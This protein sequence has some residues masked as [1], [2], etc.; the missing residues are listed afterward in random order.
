MRVKT[1]RKRNELVRAAAQVFLA[2]GFDR[3]LMSEVSERAG[4]SKGTLYRYFASKEDL[5]FAVIMELTASGT[6]P[7]FDTVTGPEV[8]FE[9]QLQR[10][11]I[12]FVK[13]AYSPQFQAMRR[14][15]FAPSENQTVSRT[16]YETAV[17]PY[18]VRTTE[19]ISQAMDDGKLRRSD[20]QVVAWH[21]CGLLE[22]ELMLRFLLHALPDMSPMQLEA[23]AGRAIAAFLAAYSPR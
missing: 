8:N 19:F 10:F 11:G 4:C 18:L 1:E 14:L 3:T 20:P 6:Q 23:V 7:I 22:S 21:L 5:Y 2:R 9:D 12:E 15:V 17:E 16:V 13:A